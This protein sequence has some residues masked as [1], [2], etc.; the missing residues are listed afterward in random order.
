MCVK[1][2]RSLLA[3]FHAIIEDLGY[4]N[5]PRIDDDCNLPHDD[6]A[7]FFERIERAFDGDAAGGRADG[8]IPHAAAVS[9]FRL[10]QLELEV[11]QLPLLVTQARSD[12]AQVG[13]LT[14]LLGQHSCSCKQVFDMFRC[15]ARA[16][17][18]PNGHTPRPQAPRPRPTA[19]L[20]PRPTARLPPPAA[21]RPR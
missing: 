1:E 10:V 7:L 11:A 18:P 8:L 2:L 6:A 16:A 21:G 15:R 4:C 9:V 20:V 13:E 14:G 19:R 12:E 3:P 17:H 5:L